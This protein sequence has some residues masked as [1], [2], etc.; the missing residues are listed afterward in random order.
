MRV[1]FLFASSL[2]RCSRGRRKI[3]KSIVGLHVFAASNTYGSFFLSSRFN[4]FHLDAS[5]LHGYQ[6]WTANISPLHAYFF[7]LTRCVNFHHPVS[8]RRFFGW[9]FS[10]LSAL[11]GA[12]ICNMILKIFK[13]IHDKKGPCTITKSQSSVISWLKCCIKRRGGFFGGLYI[14]NKFDFGLTFFALHL[15]LRRQLLD[16]AEALGGESRRVAKNQK[17][18]Q[19]AKR[20]LRV[21]ESLFF[22]LKT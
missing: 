10:S 12:K 2:A 7:L 5:T 3:V 17:K 13:K 15:K 20:A 16:Q 18:K 21:M 1:L 4:F 11:C 9:K 19:G 14:F 8:L 6:G 22:K